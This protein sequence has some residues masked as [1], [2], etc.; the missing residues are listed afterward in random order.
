MKRLSIFYILAAVIVLAL[1]S[2][3]N[4]ARKRAEPVLLS[5]AQTKHPVCFLR[6]T[7][8]MIRWAGWKSTVQGINSSILHTGMLP[9]SDLERVF[10]SRSHPIP[11]FTKKDAQ[12]CR[13]RETVHSLRF[14][15][16]PFPRKS[17]FGLSDINYI[18]SVDK[19]KLDCS[20]IYPAGHPSYRFPFLWQPDTAGRWRSGCRLADTNP[21]DSGD[22]RPVRFAKQA[23]KRVSV[24]PRF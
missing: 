22:G 5:N 9:Q 13:E 20:Q 4:A 6:M 18:Q 12:T 14:T 23:E 21:A 7:K 3:G 10:P 16:H 2:C 19:G 8:R 1:Q 24:L 15:K 11:V 17:R